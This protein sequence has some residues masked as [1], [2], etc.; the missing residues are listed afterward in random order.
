MVHDKSDSKVTEWVYHDD[1][2]LAPHL[3]MQ[4]MV[5]EPQPELERVESNTTG[6]NMI[7]F[8]QDTD[9]EAMDNDGSI[10]E[11]M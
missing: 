7:D 9:N 4:S 8:E 5:M 1:E 3:S 2:R 10:E 11:N 6:N